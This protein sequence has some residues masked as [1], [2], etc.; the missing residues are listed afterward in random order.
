MQ[1][2]SAR[3]VAALIREQRRRNG[4]S[5]AELARRVGVGRDWIIQF[6]KGKATVELGL[7]LRVLKELG[8]GLQ[9]ETRSTQ[10]DDPVRAHLNRILS[11]G[12]KAARK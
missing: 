11:G 1:I 2:K 8:I 10:T 7:V 3:E 4:W 6:E 5:Q 9:A 12:G